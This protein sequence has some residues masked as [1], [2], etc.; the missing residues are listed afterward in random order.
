MFVVGNQACWAWDNVDATLS[1][2]QAKALA[3]PSPSLEV[4]GYPHR[5]AGT[6][7]PVGSGAARNVAGKPVGFESSCQGWQQ[8]DRSMC[9]VRT[10][11][12]LRV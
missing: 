3:T 8:E 9:A 6:P 2:A 1:A 10:D 11:L 5:G 7:D 12:G 4:C